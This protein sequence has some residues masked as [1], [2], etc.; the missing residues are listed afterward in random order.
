MEAIAL[1]AVE[2]KRRRPTPEPDRSKKIRLRAAESGD[3]GAMYSR[4]PTTT[5]RCGC[6]SG[7]IAGAVD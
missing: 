5:E 2:N 7:G 3:L 1:L 4:H 6:G